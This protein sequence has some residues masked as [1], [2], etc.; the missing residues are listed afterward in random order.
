MDDPL[1]RN[2]LDEEE[3]PYLRQHAD[4][5][6][7]WQPWDEAALDAAQA[8][9]RPIFLSVGYSAC[10]WCHVMAEESFEDEAV[11][12]VLNDSF[13]PI[14][15][16]REER[17]DLDR[18]YQTICQLVTGGGG[19][20][21]SVW[22]TPEGKPFYVGTYF[23][24]QENPQRGN[25]PGFLDVCRSFAA[26]WE[27]TSDRDEIE[28]RAQQWTD[29]LRDQLETTGA[30]GTGSNGASE[31]SG[32]SASERTADDGGA[33][34]TVAKAAL[35]ATDREHGGFGSGGPKFP[36]PGRIDALLR[37]YVR[38][39]TDDALSAATTTL[40][41]MAAGGLYDHVGGGF[42][43]YATDREWTVPHFEKMLYDNAEI[44]RVYLS[45][46]QLTG[47]ESYATI[48][49][50]T[51]DFLAREFRHDE[52]GLFSTLD[53]RSEGEEG[54]YYVW[55][56]EEARE[57]IGDELTADIALDRFGIS[58]GGNFEGRTVLTI[59]ASIPD[60]A[61]T[62][63]REEREIVER[64]EDARRALFARREERVRPARDEKILA[65][66]NGLAI[67]SL[68]RGGLV[69]G[70][71]TYTDLATDALGFVREHLWDERDERLSRRYKDG[72][73]KGEAYLDDYA[74]L[75][76]GAF[77]LY[78]TTGDVD[79][80]AFALDLARVIVGE[81]Y[82]SDA[83]T[84]YLTPADGEALVTRPQELQDQSTPSSAGVATRLLLDLDAFAPGENFGDVAGAVLDTHANRIRGRP[85]E[86]VS[87][88]LAADERTRGGTEVV[89]AADAADRSDA[90]VSRESAPLPGPIP[91]PDSVRESLATTYLPDATVS[92]RPP[93]DGDLDD[94]LDALGVTEI[95]A[96]WKGR[97]MRGDEPTI[98]VCEDRTCSP[99][100][101]SLGEALGWFDDAADGAVGAEVESVESDVSLPDVGDEE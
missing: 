79:H 69:L 10:H 9:D 100:T 26:S 27:S 98:Y 78:Q 73:V 70:D 4:N 36:Q 92:P 30:E 93:S 101:H 37:S 87:L 6:V 34:G 7:H 15:V 19:W 62:Y 67:S 17:P 45:A 86:H 39:G 96:V 43:R 48:A 42:H 74:F 54:K 33:L 13:V 72:D 55:T 61:A 29:A 60:L 58:A 66:W 11:A 18:V 21:L 65:S 56:P 8:T 41:A 82:D 49:R 2:R 50:E 99:P 47:R 89:V 32:P 28:N 52:G 84:L 77:D 40:D 80:L 75:A 59:D 51:F 53:A 12:T 95:P 20:P 81:F 1:S 16:D 68:A 71:D 83:K 25:V 94:W 64:L 57:A 31:S 24:K 76:R 85:L 14:K 22:L 38:S 3:S 44:P 91:L 63:D 97:E 90:S 88:A 35:R 46:Y 23:P 5:P